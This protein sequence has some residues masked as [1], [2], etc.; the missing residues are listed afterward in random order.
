MDEKQQAALEAAFDYSEEQLPEAVPE[1]LLGRISYHCS[2]V[3]RLAVEAKRLIKELV[4]VKRQFE[5]LTKGVLP[6]LM[7]EARG[8]KSFSVDGCEIKIKEVITASCP[9]PGNTDPEQQKRRVKILRWLDANNFGH[10]ITRE[11]KVHFD[12]NAQ[13]KAKSDELMA[14]LRE[15]KQAFLNNSSVH[16]MTLN[17][18]AAKCLDDGIELPPEFKLQQFEVAQLPKEYKIKWNDLGSNLGSDED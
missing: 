14:F 13:S 11:F 12:K 6:E 15:K 2:E 7:K 3:R 17:S 5:H 4:Q 10:L 18:F 8:M 16:Y 9:A 1:D